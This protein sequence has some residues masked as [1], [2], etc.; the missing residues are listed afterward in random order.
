MSAQSWPETGTQAPPAHGSILLTGVRPYGEGD[1]T[2]VLI[3]DGI[4]AEIAPTIDAP[5]DA[6]VLDLSGQVLLPGFVDIHVHLREPGREDTETLLTG[7]Q[8]A[9]RGGFT[10][11][12][13][14]PN[15]KPVMDDPSIVESVWYKGQNIG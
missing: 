5:E 8:A 15:T 12:F 2:S 4:I 3:T 10:A 9:A 13:T 14:M 6:R 7:S 1:P 11:V